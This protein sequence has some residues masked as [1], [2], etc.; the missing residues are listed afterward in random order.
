VEEVLDP[1]LAA[2]QAQIKAEKEWKAAAA[3]GKGKDKGKTAVP[4]KKERSMKDVEADMDFAD[5]RGI[6]PSEYD[7]SGRHCNR[8]RLTSAADSG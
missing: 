4:A 2:V 8:K 6:G 1:E 7:Y 5:S 3:A